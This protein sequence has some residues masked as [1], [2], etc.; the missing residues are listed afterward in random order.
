MGIMWYDW[1]GYVGVVLILLA[2]FLL[3]TGKLRG[4]GWIYQLMNVLGPIGIML[5]LLS[6]P[7]T[8]W[9]AFFLELAWALIAIYGIAFNSRRRRQYARDGS[10]V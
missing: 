10:G 2:F 9:P 8:N 4:T 5:S 6:G 7:F 3:Q 1:C